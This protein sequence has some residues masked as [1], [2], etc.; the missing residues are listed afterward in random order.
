MSR[1]SIETW[2]AEYGESHQNKT[3]QWIHKICV[4]LIFMSIY[5][6]LF[7]I[8]FPEKRTMFLSMANLVY[9]FALIF[10]FRLS[11]KTGIIFLIIGLLLSITTMF[12]WIAVFK[13]LDVPLFRFA[14]IVFILSWIGQFIGHKIEGKKPSFIDDIKFLLIGPIWVFK[15]KK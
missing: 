13:T 14:L 1:K 9:L 10:W 4:P 2:L 7:S 11:V 5:W 12:I 15:K 3:N 8:P 6:I